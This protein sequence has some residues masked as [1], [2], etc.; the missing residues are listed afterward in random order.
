MNGL[1]LSCGTKENV[2]AKIRVDQSELL[3]GGTIHSFQV[4]I[5]RT[6]CLKDNKGKL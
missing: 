2:M 3:P 5:L 1:T 4:I 6:S